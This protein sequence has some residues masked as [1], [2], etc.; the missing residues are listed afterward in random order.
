MILPRVVS[1][2]ETENPLS[3]VDLPKP[4]PRKDEILIQV[5][6]C[7][8]CHTELDEIEGRVLPPKMPIVLGHQVVGRVIG[9]GTKV[10]RHAIGNR[11]GAGWIHDSTGEEDENLS[12]CFRATGCD[13]NGGYAE[14]MTIGENYA[15]PIPDVFSDEAAAPLLCGGAIGYRALRLCNLK[16]GD[17][18]GLMGF[19]GSAHIVIQL[20]SHLYPQTDVYVFA[21]NPATRSF[22]KELGACWTG[23]VDDPSPKKLHGIID[24]TPAWRP[25][26]QSMANL[27]PG[28]RLVVNAIRKEDRD[29]SELLKLSYHHHLWMEREIK[30][31]ANITRHDI[32]TFLPIAAEIPIKTTTKVYPLEAA[33]QALMD[34]KRGCVKGTAVLR[35]S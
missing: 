16:D 6:T 18:L 27:R 24:T 3:Q 32:K 1:L 20:V 25:V 19:G 14:Y 5:S 10:T 22:A 12:E 26:V 34:L 8:V 33:N 2:E 31:V 30:T 7:G 11:V 4:T 35:I 28:G 13:V 9:R 21:R 15:Y 29:K 17:R 23:S